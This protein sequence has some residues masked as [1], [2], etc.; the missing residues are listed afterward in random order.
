MSKASKRPSRAS[1]DIHEAI[2]AQA[3]ALRTSPRFGFRDAEDVPEVAALM[4]C[5][6]R[7]VEAG[8]PKSVLFE[9]RRYWLTVRL[10]IQFDVYASPGDGEPLIT[11][12][13]FSTE[14]FGHMPGH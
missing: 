4:A 9:G 13:T 11:G 6:R 5:C 2:R 14:N 1:R 3:E 10:A 12:A 7:E 8:V